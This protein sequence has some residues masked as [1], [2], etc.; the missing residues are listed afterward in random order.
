MS[1]EAGRQSAIWDFPGG[2][3]AKAPC[4]QC[5][6]GP[7]QILVGELDPMCCNEEWACLSKDPDVSCCNKDL[8]QSNIRE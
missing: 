5:K 1:L 8:L 6:G 4:S 2:P 3:V 7:A